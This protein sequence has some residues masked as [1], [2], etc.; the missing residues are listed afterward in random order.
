[1]IALGGVVGAVRAFA[2]RSSASSTA[3]KMFPFAYRSL[4]D[5]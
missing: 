5:R 2:G 4:C 3:A 1:L